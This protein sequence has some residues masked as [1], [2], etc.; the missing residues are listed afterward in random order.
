MAQLLPSESDDNAPLGFSAARAHEIHHRRV[1]RAIHFV[2][3]K[4]L[5]SPLLSPTLQVIVGG[6]ALIGTILALFA[7]SDAGL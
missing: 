4:P 5:V 3:A 6:V 2:E 7:C 1:I